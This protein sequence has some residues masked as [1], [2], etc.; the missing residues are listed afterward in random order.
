VQIKNTK[1]LREKISAKLTPRIIPT[2]SCSNKALDKTTLASIKKMPPLTPVKLQKEVIHIS[3]FFKNIKPIKPVNIM[4][5]KSYVQASKQSY[6]NNTSEVI[7]IKNTFSTLDAQKVDQ[8][9]K[10]VNGSPKPKLQIQMTTKGPSRKQIIIPMSN[11][12]I[13]KFI[14]TVHFT[15]PILT[16]LSRTPNLRS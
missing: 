12:N 4:S 15:L 3:K 1:S 16:N 11:D 13:I 10:I 14:K 6:M 7:K 8:I 2:P 5:T 9:H